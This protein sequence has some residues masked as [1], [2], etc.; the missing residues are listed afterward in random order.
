MTQESFGNQSGS[1]PANSGA[2]GS[3]GNGFTR[4]LRGIYV[5]LRGYFAIIGLLVS[6]M[7]VL[8]FVILARFSSEHAGVSPVPSASAHVD[9]SLSLEL[10]GDLVE[11]SPDLESRIIGRFFSHRE[12]IYLPELRSSLRKAAKDPKVRGLFVDLSGMSGSQAQLAELRRMLVDFRAADKT[13]H[14]FTP[15]LGVGDLFV[16]S[17]AS[18][19]IGPPSMDVSLPGPVFGLVYFGEALRKLGFEMEVIR[20]GKYKAAFEPFI[21][22]KPSAETVENYTATENALREW[23]VNAIAEGRGKTPAEVRQWLASSLYT[24]KAALAAGIITQ[25]AYVEEAREATIKVSNATEDMGFADWESEFSAAITDDD[26]STT[27]DGLA[28]IEAI[29]EINLEP[30]EGSEEKISVAAITEEI[31]WAAEEE[32]AKAVVLRVSSPGGSALASDLIWKELADLAKKKP[33]VVSMGEVAASGGYYIAAPANRILAEPTTITGSIG[34]IGMLPKCRGCST[35]YGVDFH[36]ISGSERRSLFNF[37]TPSSAEDKKI[38][39]DSIDA[40]YQLFLERVAEGRKMDVAA[41]DLLAQGRIYSGTEALNIKLVD[42]LG[43][44]RDA[45]NEAK[46]LGGLD[47]AKLYP[48]LRYQGDELSLTDCLR[49]PTKLMECMRDLE[50][51]A[52]S[53]SA[54]SRRAIRRGIETKVAR[55]SAPALASPL[56][57][58]ARRIVESFQKEPVQMRMGSIVVQQGNG[59]L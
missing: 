10:A 23:Y 35:K 32:K 36:V 38:I 1:H 4:V 33:L 3:S 41:V 20:H 34:V 57:L 45:F 15:T 21:M 43:G 37:G 8:V 47:A 14:V 30:G 48:I 16:A 2:P 31:R 6:L 52:R 11:K 27:G 56:V 51:G 49:S 12:T 59:T 9:R 54:A 50:R 53:V 46:T 26:V 19:I 25:L 17:A 42:Q 28:L 29:G 39:A 44:L 5:F 24:P 13:L 55:D 58:E 7:P 22:N 18:E 40:A